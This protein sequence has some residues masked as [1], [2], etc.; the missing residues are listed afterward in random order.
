MPGAGTSAC[1]KSAAVLVTLLTD[2]SVSLKQINACMRLEG[3][4]WAVQVTNHYNK[5]NHPCDQGLYHTSPH[6]RVAIPPAVREQLMRLNKSSANRRSI[7]KFVR[8]EAGSNIIMYEIHNLLAKLK[9]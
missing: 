9:T 1:V 4:A 7:M 3:G 5:H 8:H 2:L 6:V